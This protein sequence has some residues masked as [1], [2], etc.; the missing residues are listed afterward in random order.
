LKDTSKVPEERL[1]VLRDT[2][3]GYYE[4]DSSNITKE[5]IQ[6]AADMDPKYY[7]Y[8]SNVIFNNINNY[9]SLV[10]IYLFCEKHCTMHH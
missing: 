7:Y 2:V 4:V 10:T 5:M 9:L 6:K 1:C 8:Y 3:A